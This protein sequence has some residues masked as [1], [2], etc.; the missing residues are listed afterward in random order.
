[1]TKSEI[2]FFDTLAPTWDENEILSTPD[3]IRSILGK[4]RI[5]KGMD[6]LDLGTGTGVLVPYLSEMVGD[7]GHV[8][9]IDLSDGMLSLARQKYGH[10]ENVE[11]L[12]LDFEEEQI[13]GKYDV[14]L[15]YSVYP[16]LHAPA[17]TIEWL[18]KM[19]MKPDGR[20]VIAF[21]SDEEFINNIHHERK[22]EHDHL[23]PAHV[24]AEMIRNWG[25]RAEVL[26]ATPDEYIVEIKNL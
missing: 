5:S 20:I 2:E 15:L 4:L 25:F 12:R 11:F 7:E 3:R 26:A 17:D 9:A 16:H 1:M 24:L 10:L 21:P 23:P 19:N 18:F 8:T 22:A 6:I 13:P 14:A